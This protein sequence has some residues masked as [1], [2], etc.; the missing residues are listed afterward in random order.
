MIGDASF[1]SNLSWAIDSKSTLTLMECSDLD[2][3]S[4]LE[5]LWRMDTYSRVVQI[6]F[7]M[8]NMGLA[9]KL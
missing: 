8:M 2:L 9:Q 1:S 3:S 5:L 4:I 6:S 7:K